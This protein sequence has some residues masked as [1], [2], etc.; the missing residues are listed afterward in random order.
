MN[1]VGNFTF[2]LSLF[3]ERKRFFVGKETE[4][5]KGLASLEGI[6]LIAEEALLKMERF[7]LRA[8]DPLLKDFGCHVHGLNIAKMGSKILFEP[9]FRTELNDNLIS[10]QRKREKLQALSKSLG[11]L[12]NQ[13]KRKQFKTFVSVFEAQPTLREVLQ[14]LD[15]LIILSDKVHFIILSYLLT[16]TREFKQITAEDRLICEQCR[17]PITERDGVFKEVTNSKQLVVWVK[18][19][20]KREVNASFLERDVYIIAKRLLILASHRFIKKATFNSGNLRSLYFLEN[21]GKTIQCKPELPIYYT[22]TTV[23]QCALYN[24]MPVVLLFKSYGHLGHVYYEKAAKDDAGLLLMPSESMPVFDA[25]PLRRRLGNRPVMVVIVKKDD[26]DP[27]AFLKRL[28]VNFDFLRLCKLDGAQ[29]KQF[30]DSELHQDLSEEIPLLQSRKFSRE[31]VKLQNLRIEARTYGVA[32]NSPNAWLSFSHVFADTLDQYK[33]AKFFQFFYESSRCFEGLQRQPSPTVSAQ[34]IAADKR[35]AL[36]RSNKRALYQLVPTISDPSKGTTDTLVKKNELNAFSDPERLEQM[37]EWL[38]D[39]STEE[40]VR[41]QVSD[42]S[43]S[44]VNFALNKDMKNPF[45]RRG[46]T[47]KVAKIEK[48][49]E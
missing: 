34:F 23:F 29:L 7:D 19:R 32:I 12:E 15:L 6:Y 45:S 14:K 36:Q 44:A 41:E 17:M 24:R 5:S 16:L 8:F 4:F 42:R 35:K 22:L 43:K 26:G 11:G 10:L 39:I 40:I 13:E 1:A 3:R 21:T 9:K 49:I 31:A 27:G 48:V 25:K 47:A 18:D 37:K 46:G 30:T 28:M 38:D 2:P 20:V 33:T